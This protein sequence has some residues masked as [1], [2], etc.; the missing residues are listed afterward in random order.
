VRQPAA[1]KKVAKLNRIEKFS[2][3]P[4]SAGSKLQQSSALIAA[5]VVWPEAGSHSAV[6]STFT[7]RFAGVFPEGVNKPDPAAPRPNSPFEQAAIKARLSWLAQ[8][9]TATSA[10]WRFSGSSF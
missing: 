10:H 7:E 2:G 9:T 6:G 1:P 4:Q 3:Q 5:R 8:D